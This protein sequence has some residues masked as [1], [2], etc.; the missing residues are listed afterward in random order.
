[1]LPPADSP[2]AKA[3]YE[4]MRAKLNFDPRAGGAR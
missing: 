3:L 1:V 4:E 2:Q